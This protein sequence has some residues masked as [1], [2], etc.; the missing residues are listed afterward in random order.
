MT[1]FKNKYRTTS[2]RAQWW[3]YGWNGA[4]FI[5]ICAAGRNHFFGEVIDGRMDLSRT[6]VIADILW[7]DIPCRSSHV[8]LGEF[9]IMPNHI[10]GILILDRPEI[11]DTKPVQDATDHQELESLPLDWQWAPPETYRKNKRMSEISPKAGSI[12]TILRSYKSGVTKHANRLGFENGWQTRFHDHIIRDHGEYQRIANY[13]R[14]NPI[15]WK[16]DKFYK[17]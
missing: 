16:N 6:G 17:S 2:S 5:T 15:N 11:I 8:E 12:S 1:K 9:I 4:Y 3:N 13:I 14:N 7:H 10:H